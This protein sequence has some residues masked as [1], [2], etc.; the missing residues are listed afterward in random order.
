M[1][2]PHF[3]S[4]RVVLIQGMS[5]FPLR[6]DSRQAQVSLMVIVSVDLSYNRGVGQVSDRNSTMLVF[7]TRLR[8][9]DNSR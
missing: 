5:I 8:F 4:M 7:E 1:G 6:V 3:N 2:M 9:D